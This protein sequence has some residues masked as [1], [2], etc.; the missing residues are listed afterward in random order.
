MQI[1]VA[2]LDAA[3]HWVQLNAA[4][5]SETPHLAKLATKLGSSAKLELDGERLTVALA[6]AAPAAPDPAPDPAGGNP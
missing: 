6:D 1:I 4:N 2:T 5:A 3:T